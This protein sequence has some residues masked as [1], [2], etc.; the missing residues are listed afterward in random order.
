MPKVL[1]LIP[2][3]ELEAVAAGMHAPPSAAR[4]CLRRP[5]GFEVT[6]LCNTS[7]KGQSQQP[8]AVR[9]DSPNFGGKETER[10]RERGRQKNKMKLNRQRKGERGFPARTSWPGHSV[11]AHHMAGQSIFTVAENP[12]PLIVGFSYNKDPNK[13]PLLSETPVYPS[14]QLLRPKNLKPNRLRPQCLIAAESGLPRCAKLG[15]GSKGGKG[16]PEAYAVSGFRL[17]KPYT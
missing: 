10:E 16:M 14:P 17:P 15:R 9:S 3:R 4:R 6:G 2:Y 7:R 1:Y 8:A 13:V 12:G 5:A 11:P